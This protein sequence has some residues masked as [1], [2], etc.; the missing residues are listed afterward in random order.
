[1][2]DQADSNPLN[3]FSTIEQANKQAYLNIQ[4]D[5]MPVGSS[6]AS[7]PRPEIDK[8]NDYIDICTLVGTISERKNSLM[9]LF[10]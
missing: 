5:F 2:S 6:T 1:M 9:C 4:V 3:S 8:A 7:S 10:R